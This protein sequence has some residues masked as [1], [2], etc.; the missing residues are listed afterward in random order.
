M[1][2]TPQVVTNILTEVEN[3]L[4]ESKGPG[5]EVGEIQCKLEVSPQFSDEI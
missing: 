2:I 5:K 4:G 1:G 3:K